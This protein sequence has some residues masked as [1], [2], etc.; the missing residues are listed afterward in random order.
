MFV[1]V[2]V[3]FIAGDVSFIRASPVLYNTY[4]SCNYAGEV[5]IYKMYNT[6]PNEVLAKLV[7]VCGKIPEEV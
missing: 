5:I 3:A 4:T 2:I 6:T 7:H 1:L